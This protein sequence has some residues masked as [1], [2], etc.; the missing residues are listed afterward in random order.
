MAISSNRMA[1]LSELLAMLSLSKRD[2][3]LHAKEAVSANSNNMTMRFIIVR[4]MDE[5]FVTGAS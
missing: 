1:T 4:S 2:S 5:S 3:S